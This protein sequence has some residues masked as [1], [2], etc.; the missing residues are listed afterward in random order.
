MKNFLYMIYFCGYFLDNFFMIKLTLLKYCFAIFRLVQVVKWSRYI[1]TSIILIKPIV[2]V[3]FF[4]LKPCCWV[5]VKSTLI[6]WLG[7][8]L[9]NKKR[10]NKF[11]TK[12]QNFFFTLKVVTFFP[13]INKLHS[14]FHFS[15]NINCNFSVLRN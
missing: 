4:F 12:L 10:K 5:P 13:S 6:V 14:L 2:S 8:V 3:P 15:L 11:P 7:K 1:K 9:S